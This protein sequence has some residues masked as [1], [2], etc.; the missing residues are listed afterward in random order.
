MLSR[1][2]FVK[3]LT[4]S[5]KSECFDKAWYSSAMLKFVY[6]IGSWPHCPLH[7]NPYQVQAHPH[8]ML[9]SEFRFDSSPRW[10]LSCD[11]LNH[12]E[13]SSS[14]QLLRDAFEPKRSLNSCRKSLQVNVTSVFNTCLAR[15]HCLQKS[16]NMKIALYHRN[17]LTLYLND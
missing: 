16:G 11:V 4:C 15:A 13:E 5:N 10:R 9:S 3:T 6:V 7:R 8:S 1:N 17:L 14:G 2:N 12:E